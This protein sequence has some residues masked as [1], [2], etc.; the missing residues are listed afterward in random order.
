[1]IEFILWLVCAFATMSVAIYKNRNGVGWLAIGAILPIIS[2][3]FV[4]VM[5]GLQDPATLKKCP[6]CAETCLKEAKICKHCGSE[7]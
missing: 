4:S 2:L 7:F 1:M 3:I 6:Q 5:P